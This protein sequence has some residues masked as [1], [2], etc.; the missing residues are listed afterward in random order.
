MPL[1]IRV[2]V[3]EMRASSF[4]MDYSIEDENTGRVTPALAAQSSA[5]TGRSV[6]VTYDD[7]AG[8]SIPIPP[9][10]RAKIEVFERGPSS[11]FPRG[12][13]N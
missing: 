1:V 2:R 8:Q 7:A 10:W 4:L 12:P 5:A 11:E 13:Q 9:E 6:N 3:T